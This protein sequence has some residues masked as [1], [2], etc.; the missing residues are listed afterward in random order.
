[1]YRLPSYVFSST[2]HGHKRD[3]KYV[4]FLGQHRIFTGFLLLLLEN[5]NLDMEATL[6]NKWVIKLK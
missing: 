3:I 6:V 4:V 1:M 2:I 5:I